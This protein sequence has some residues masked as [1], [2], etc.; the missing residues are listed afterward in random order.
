MGRQCFGMPA[1]LELP[2]FADCA[3]VC[4]QLGLDFVELNMNMPQYQLDRL[5]P[6]ELRRQACEKRIGFTIH[7]E[8]ELNPFGFNTCVANAYLE[9]VLKTIGLAAEAGIPVLN[10]HMPE[11]VHFTLP[12]HKA[13]LFDI[14]RDHYLSRVRMFRDACEERIG[15][16]GIIICVENTGGYLPFQKEGVGELLKSPVFGLTWD[17]GHDHSAGDADAEFIRS[18]LGRL[19]HMHIH[20]ALGESNHLPLGMGEIDL[21]E[22]LEVARQCGCRCLLEVK[23]LSALKQSIEYLKRRKLWN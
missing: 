2:G 11:G 8:E 10:M 5:N 16:E 3:E 20:D 19:C 23:T 21:V 18:H 14:Y 15:S 4:A 6:L 12:D 7:M 22:R 13:Y 17:I 1:M 9:T